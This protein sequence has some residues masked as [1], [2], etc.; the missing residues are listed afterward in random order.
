MRE[1]RNC[2]PVSGTS[3]VT[4]RGHAMPSEPITEAEVADW[5]R[6]HRGVNEKGLHEPV[7]YVCHSCRETWPCPTSCLLALI[8]RLTGTSTAAPEG[9]T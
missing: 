4:E 7:V 1:R 2:Q 9:T 6:L 3:M 8:D 5:D